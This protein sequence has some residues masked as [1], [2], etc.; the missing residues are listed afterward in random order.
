[1]SELSIIPCS[2][3]HRPALVRLAAEVVRD[4]TVFPFEDAGGVLDYWSGA[5]TRAFVALRGDAVAGTYVLKPNH[6]GRGS[7][8][9]NAGYL[10]AE[11]ERG[12]GVGAAL[13]RHSLETA[14]TLGYL[15]MQ[16]NQVVSTNLPAL[17]LW[18]RL[19]FRVLAEIPGAFRHPELGYVSTYVMFREL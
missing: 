1:V 19:G 17:A 14:R 7:H 16:F 18:R 5:G 12:R 2:D 10:V 15:A 11:T 9:C 3:H 13:G 4:G 6:P 8:V